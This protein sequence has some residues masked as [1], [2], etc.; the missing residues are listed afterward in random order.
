MPPM[1]EKEETVITASRKP[2]PSPREEQAGAR[3]G[4]QQ[5]L[6]EGEDCG[7]G[8]VALG[9]GGLVREHALAVVQQDD[10][11]MV[12]QGTLQGLEGPV[13]VGKL[14]HGV[15]VAIGEELVAE[16][17]EQG[18]GVAVVLQAG[19]GGALEAGG[20]GEPAGELGGQGGL[21]R[22][23]GAADHGPGL[24]VQEPLQG[25]ELA[26]AALEA[27]GRLCPGKSPRLSLRLRASSGWTSR[28]GTWVMSCGSCF[29]W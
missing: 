24:G 23:A 2:R 7:Q 26:A 9:W 21:A 1:A 18:A 29:S 6:A 8:L 10:G 11:R 14:R 22:P 3:V 28:A 5:A 16:G 20:A 17:V 25:Q 27:V 19:E 15:L 13:Q 4:G 12:G